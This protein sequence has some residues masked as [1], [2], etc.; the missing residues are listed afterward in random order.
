MFR[1]VRNDL[2][3]GG[4]N[5]LYLAVG[6]LKWK[7]KPEDTTTYRAPLLL[8]PVKLN[9][10][11]AM[12]PFLLSK[13]EDEA[14]FNATLIQ[15]LKKDFARNL[16]QFESN[17]PTDD[18]GVDV[19]LILERVRAEVRDIP[20]FEVIDECAISTFSFSK[21]L[22]WKDLVDRTRHLEQNRVVRHLI[23]DPDK[24]FRS[25]TG[26]SFPRPQEM[27]KRFDPVEIYHPLP[28]DS[29]QLAA[30]MAASEGRDFVLIGPPGTGKSQTIANMICQC[31]AT[32]KTVMFVAEKTAALDVVY[33]RLRERGLGDCCLELHSNKAERR[34]FL[35]Q[36][37]SA[38]RNNRRAPGHDW[39]TIS[40]RLKVRRDELNG[41]VNAIHQPHANGWT[42]YRAFGIC[43]KSAQQ[44]APELPWPDTV[45]HDR[46]AY[47]KLEA[48]VQQMALTFGAVDPSAKLPC[49]KVSQWS[50]GWKQICFLVALASKPLPRHY[51]MLYRSLRQHWGCEVSPMRHLSRSMR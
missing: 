5:T 51:V 43:A 29:S 2:A 25:E 36:L 44:P 41:Y 31:L 8:V 46:A 33:R 1:T 11:S 38:W 30:V 34:K 18:S 42:A 9:R 19:E 28:A 6:F 47:D 39:L 14:R 50:A 49:I 4:S 7:Q 37:D 10:K 27:D 48:V 26:G 3:E 15:L 22:M 32:G 21:Y 17:L 40:E 23:R 12:S 20:G 45:Q 16:T 24:P 13:H 35:D